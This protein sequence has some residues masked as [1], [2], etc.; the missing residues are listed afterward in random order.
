MFGFSIFFGG[1]SMDP[2]PPSECRG[3]FTPAGGAM[4]F[5]LAESEAGSF[6]A[7]LTR[8]L[9]SG[10]LEAEAEEGG[11]VSLCTEGCLRGR[12]PDWPICVAPKLACGCRAARWLP[13]VSGVTDGLFF[14][15]GRTLSRIVA[16][17]GWLELLPTLLGKWPGEPLCL[18]LTDDRMGPGE[19]T[20]LEWCLKKRQIGKE[21]STPKSIRNWKR[22]QA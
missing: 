9:R 16:T 6:R 19:S 10:L 3:R 15:A 21:T 1:S 12:W 22:D 5:R 11:G 17:D 14:S 7:A 18:A 13:E 20:S 4:L 8:P 2:A